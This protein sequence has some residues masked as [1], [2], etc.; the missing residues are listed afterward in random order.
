MR[1]SFC[2]YR[3]I[4]RQNTGYNYQ[5]RA[6]SA[7]NGLPGVI[8]SDEGFCSSALFS[9]LMT[10][11]RGRNQRFIKK[12]TLLW[13]IAGYRPQCEVSSK[14]SQN[15]VGSNPC[16]ES[17]C[18]RYCFDRKMPGRFSARFSVRRVSFW[19]SRQLCPCRDSVVY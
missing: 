14:V 17:M 8:L 2:I 16:G 10:A 5:I 13:T 19:H 6:M 18:L 15:S 12:C 9:L 1:I 7:R 3:L 11:F 4:N